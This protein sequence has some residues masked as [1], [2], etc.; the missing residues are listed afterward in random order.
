MEDWWNE[1]AWHFSHLLSVLVRSL[2]E[3]SLV[4]LRKDTGC[5]KPLLLLTGIRG[6][7]G[8]FPI[9]PMHFGI[10]CL[11]TLAFG[12]L[13]LKWLKWCL[14]PLL[15]QRDGEPG[16]ELLFSSLAAAVRFGLR[17]SIGSVQGL[18]KLLLVIKVI[19]NQVRILCITSFA[20]LTQRKPISS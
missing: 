18:P 4:L 2:M 5:N 7:K 10:S 15:R 20:V 17:L 3:C 8:F 6:V 11:T 16:L 9:D 13:L 19:L 1:I 14:K 12:S